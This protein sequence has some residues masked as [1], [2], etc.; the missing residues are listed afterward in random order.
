MQGLYQ[1]GKQNPGREIQWEELKQGASY[2]GL[3][4]TEAKESKTTR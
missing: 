1:S 2:K 3:G 4:R